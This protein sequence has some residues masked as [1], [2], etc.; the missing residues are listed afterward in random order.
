MK[1]RLSEYLLLKISHHINVICSR[2]SDSDF[3]YF[4]ALSGLIL[5]IPFFIWLIKK[6][7]VTINGKKLVKKLFGQ[8]MNDYEIIKI[9]YLDPLPFGVR[10]KVV[11]EVKK[12]AFRRIQGC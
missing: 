10:D 7:I 2:L 12:S 9:H 4:R 8:G 11:T 1:R 5:F 6:K 3:I